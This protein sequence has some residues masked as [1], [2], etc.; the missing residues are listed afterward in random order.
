MN[1]RFSD[2]A[3]LNAPAYVRHSRLKDWVAEVASLTQPDRIVWA[4]GSQEEYDR[5]CG[6]MVASGSLIKLNPEKRPD[7]YLAWSDPSD[8]ARRSE[9]RRV[10]KEC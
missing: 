5:L 4:D 3:A 9:E 1:Q 8:V 10:G 6:E 7:S 2:P